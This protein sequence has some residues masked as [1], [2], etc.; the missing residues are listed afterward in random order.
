M[1]L[2]ASQHVQSSQTKDGTHVSPHWQADSYPPRKSYQSHLEGE[3]AVLGWGRQGCP[4]VVCTG[5]FFLCSDKV[6][7]WS[8][9]LF[10]FIVITDNTIWYWCEIV[11]SQRGALLSGMSQDLRVPRLRWKWQARHC[12]SVAVFLFLVPL[13]FRQNEVRPQD[14][15]SS[16][17]DENWLIEIR[18]GFP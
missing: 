18:W 10:Y 14:I 11:D 16:C 13:S 4:F 7:M 6:M 12:V 17:L 5:M 3:P 9:L 1:G 15:D 2:A 8:W